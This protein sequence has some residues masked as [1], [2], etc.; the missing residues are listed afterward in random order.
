[1]IASGRASNRRQN[2]A[3]RLKRTASG[4]LKRASGWKQHKLEGKEPKRRR[5]L[6]KAG[7]ISKADEPRLSVLVPYL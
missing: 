6:R 2:W 3:K 5:R 4:R 7:M 1:V